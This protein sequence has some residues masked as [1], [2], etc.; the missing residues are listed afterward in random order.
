M[1]ESAHLSPRHLSINASSLAP[2]LSHGRSGP[3]SPSLSMSSIQDA[4]NPFL[5]QSCSFNTAKKASEM[6]S[7]QQWS[8]QYG[9]VSVLAEERIAHQRVVEELV[10]KTEIIKNDTE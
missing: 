2:V 10:E 9:I 7:H 1:S 3:H 5:F 8:E 6:R 4:P